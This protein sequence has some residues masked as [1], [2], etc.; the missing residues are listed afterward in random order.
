MKACSLLVV[1]SALTASALV[2][3]MDHGAWPD[4][5]PKEMEA[6]REQSRT[7]EW[8]TGTQE[9]SHTI[10]FKSREE[11]EKYWPVL[12]SLLKPGAKLTLRFPEK[13]ASSVQDLTK[14][15]VVIQAPA[16]SVAFDGKKTFKTGYEWPKSA[17]LPNGQL[18]EYVYE[19]GD[20]EE[21]HYVPMLKGD[22]LKGFHYRARI[23]IMLICDGKIIDLNRIRFPKGVIVEDLREM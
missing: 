5:W 21:K 19:K 17:Y 14:T 12:S 18:P 10:P 23:D 15:S 22:E 7:T 4:T 16:A 2:I 3:P 1:L 13:T 11:F 9:D 6:L 8:A 20:K